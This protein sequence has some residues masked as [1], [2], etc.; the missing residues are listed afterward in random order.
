V[1]GGQRRSDT[2]FVYLPWSAFC[3][4]HVSPI[5]DRLHDNQRCAY[6][7]HEW[8]PPR[9][10]VVDGEQF[11]ESDRRLMLAAESEELRGPG[12]DGASRCTP[13]GRAKLVLAAEIGPRPGGWGQS[14]HGVGLM[15]SNDA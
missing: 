4:D 7:Q 14:L 8:K 3:D 6:P 2:R 5:I 12:T 11:P 10:I 9:V 15:R 13:I 1:S